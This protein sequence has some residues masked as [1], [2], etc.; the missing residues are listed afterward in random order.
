MGTA[1]QYF[2]LAAELAKT[3]ADAQAPA[4]GDWLPLDWWPLGV[5]AFT[6]TETTSSNISIRLAISKDEVI[7]DNNRYGDP[8]NQVM[9]GSMDKQTQRVAFTVGDNTTN[10][11]ETGIY[12]L[13]KDEAHCLIHLGN[14]RTEQWLLVR[15]TRKDV[16][17]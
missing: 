1:Q 15:A 14:E 16:T 6:N 17:S 4:D 13:T 5:S 3:G 7:R 12:N 2:G 9:Q 10:I 11:I 8:K